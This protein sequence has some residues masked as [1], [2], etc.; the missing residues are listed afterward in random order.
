MVEVID[1]APRTPRDHRVI[2]EQRLLAAAEGRKP[3]GGGGVRWPR[4]TSPP[5]ELERRAAE[6]LPAPGQAT[7]AGAVRPKGRRADGAGWLSRLRLDVGHGRRRRVHRAASVVL[8][9]MPSP[10]P[11]SSALA[12]VGLAWSS[13]P[14]RLRPA[15]GRPRRLLR[16]TCGG[17]RAN[18]RLDAA[19]E[20]GSAGVSASRRVRRTTA[21]RRLGRQA[22]SLTPRVARVHGHRGGRAAAAVAR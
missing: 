20:W 19:G 18:R 7:S 14:G 21:G 8:A 5:R 11:R 16:V 12:P 2:R 13:A 15:N 4:G 9:D 1:P 3:V 6:Q 22:R 10:P 17:A